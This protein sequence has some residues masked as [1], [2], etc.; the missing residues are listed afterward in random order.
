MGDKF[1]PDVIVEEHASK[2]E[3]DQT[4]RSKPRTDQPP[5]RQIALRSALGTHSSHAIRNHLTMNSPAGATLAR[6]RGVT[7]GLNSMLG[8]IVRFTCSLFSCYAAMAAPVAN[9]IPH[10]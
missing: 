10:A 4:H 9:V 8:R 1:T 3:R 6:A 5:A 7:V 2:H